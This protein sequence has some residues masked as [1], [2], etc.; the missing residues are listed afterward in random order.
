MDRGSAKKLV[1]A[2]RDPRFRVDLGKFL[3]LVAKDYHISK[4]FLYGSVPPPNDS[5]EG[6]QGEEL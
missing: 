4:A 1:D 3:S 6:S 5:L 2:N